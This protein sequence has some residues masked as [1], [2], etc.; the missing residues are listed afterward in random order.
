MIPDPCARFTGALTKPYNTKDKR[1]MGGSEAKAISKED[2][3]K[4]TKAKAE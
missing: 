1:L 2:S 4:S 3:G